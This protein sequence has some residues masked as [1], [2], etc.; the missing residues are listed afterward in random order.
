L[1]DDY[2][3][4]IGLKKGLDEKTWD[5]GQGQGQGQST[6]LAE[7]VLSIYSHLNVSSS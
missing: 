1:N 5:L 2:V 6:D 3:H 7:C 4:D